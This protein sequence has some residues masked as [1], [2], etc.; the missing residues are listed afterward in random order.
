MNK[1]IFCTLFD[2][3]YLSR[4]L[5]M[6]HSLVNVCPNFHLYI[7]AFDNKALKVLKLLNLEHA[8]IISL[9]EFED[10]KLLG[11]KASRSPGEYCWTCTSS[12][13]K[14]VLEKFNTASCTY[15]D[16]DLFFYSNPSSLIEQMENN[17]VQITSHRYT[18]RYD[19]SKKSGTYCVQF[20][21]FKNDEAGLTVLN[22][23]REKCIDWCYNRH[24]DGKFG[25]Q[26]YLDDW[27]SRFEG[28]HDL[29]H[30]G[31][32]I[33][34]WNIQQYLFN[35]RNGEFS[36]QEIK[37]GKLYPVV[38]YH[39]HQLKLLRNNFTDL[40]RYVLTKE[41]INLIYKPY[42]KKLHITNV[43]LATRFPEMN[44][45]GISAVNKSW[46]SPLIRLKRML[47]NE[48]HVYPLDKFL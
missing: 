5:V 12:T 15:L 32:G 25:D 31:G 1:L 41:Q 9:Q 36:I 44:N 43:D 29:E 19:Q 45:A 35:N 39:F 13:I 18:P 37:T 38:F 16:A 26:K 42:V 14:Y 24:E 10:E 23:W 2:S 30:L 21:T 4:G 47:L 17:S 6:Y 27:T 48:Y 34:P 46:K 3:N 40:C 33:A 8:T 28:V 20:V 7:F 11:V 22:W